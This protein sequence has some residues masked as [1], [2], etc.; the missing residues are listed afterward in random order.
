MNN[1]TANIIWILH[2]NLILFIL[3]VPFMDCNYLLL[4]N[5]ILIPTLILHWLT[6]DNT[7]ALTT[8]EKY[9]RNVKTKEE[10]KECFTY[11]LIHPLF[12]FQKNNIDIS[13][14]I[15]VITILLWLICIIKLSTK[16]KNGEIKNVRDLLMVR[17]PVFFGKFLF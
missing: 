7:C 4:L 16:Y 11:Q 14:F 2:L 8:I 3:I 5:S 1:V 15:Y 12:E 6:N 10:E 17:R 13:F 9:M